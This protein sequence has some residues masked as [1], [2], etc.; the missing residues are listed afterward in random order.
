[1]R[2]WFFILVINLLLFPV[3]AGAQERVVDATNN[4]PISAAS[5]M[6]VEGNVVGFTL[7]DGTFPEI[8]ESSYPITVRCIGYEQL[9]IKRPRGKSWEMKPMVYELEEVV[10]SPVRRNVLKQTFYAREYFSFTTK[11]DTVTI[12]VEH[13]ADRFIPIGKDAKFGGS[14][15]LR[16]LDSRSYARYK[17][18][19]RDSVAMEEKSTVPTILSVLEPNDDAVTAPESFKSGDAVKYYEE[20]GKSGIAVIQKQNTQVFTTIEDALAGKKEHSASPWILKLLGMTLDIKQLYVT[21]AYRTNAEG[22]YLPEDLIENGFVM[23][24]DGRG[25]LFRKIVESDEPVLIRSMLEMY[26]VDRERLT[27]DEAKEQ[28]KNQPTNVKYLIPS[29]VPALNAATRKMVERA[30]AEVKKQ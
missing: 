1:M 26:V 29:T 21:H 11:S 25:K 9:V 17:V 5:I 15:S 8:S 28:Y 30:I 22:V 13:M 10:I 6:D 27:K 19:D 20:S 12:F 2:R 14:S 7:Y 3:L 4:T 18:L 23:E 24:A 16:L